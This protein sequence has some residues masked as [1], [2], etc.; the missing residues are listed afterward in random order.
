[1]HSPIC[2]SPSV[3]AGQVGPSELSERWTTIVD[4]PQVAVPEV[5]ETIRIVAFRLVA[6][7]VVKW[8][9]VCHVPVPIPSVWDGF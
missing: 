3:L 4:V 7:F 5:F 9:D 1:M 2:D 6:K 8:Q